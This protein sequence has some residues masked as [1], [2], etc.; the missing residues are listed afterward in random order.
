MDYPAPLVIQ[1][2]T[3]PHKH[4]L[5]LL[6]GRGSSGEKFGRALLETPIP[7]PPGGI[8]TT[9]T[10]STPSPT[11]TLDQVFPHARF[12]FP[13]AAHRRATL[14]RRAKTHQWFDNWELVPPATFREELQSPGLQETT[15]YI[16]GL[17]RAEIADVPGGASDVVVGGLS[18][19]CAAS[20]I[21]MLLWEGEP[22][23]A[24][25]GMCGFLPFCTRLLEQSD[26]GDAAGG[27][28]N[29][30]EGDDA[31]DPFEREED[32]SDPDSQ[33]PAMRA[34]SWLREEIQGPA[35][36]PRPT[37]IVFRKIPAFLG[38][39]SEDAQVSVILGRNASLCLRSAGIDVS[40]REYESLGHW[41][42][43]PMLRDL[44]EFLQ[45][46][47]NLE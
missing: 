24:V 19:G 3:L 32:D 13:T 46:K 47:T 2:R 10:S 11:T 5:I 42:S 6:H 28:S 18:Q 12:V 7:I 14:Y 41:Y 17:I 37:D 8:P 16:H 33:D 44:V 26:L 21:A 23:G 15:G 27:D 9:G 36:S 25:V 30:T 45:A 22:L 40:W 1:P 34:V 29:E 38:H 4:T 39:G 20:L 31:F 43:G 35:S